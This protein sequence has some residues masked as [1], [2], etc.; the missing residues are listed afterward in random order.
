MLNN[1]STK[2]NIL[3]VF[4]AIATT[5]FLLVASTFIQKSYSIEIGDVSPSNF[6]ATRQVEDRVTTNRLRDEARDKAITV[7]RQDPTVEVSIE[8]RLNK[9]FEELIN[10]RTINEINLEGD[11]IYDIN[12]D[13]ISSNVLQILTIEEANYIVNMEVSNF[14]QFKSSIYNMFKSLLENGIREDEI[15]SLQLNIYS[16][17]PTLE[18]H[19]D[20]ARVAYA[21][22]S[23][24]IQPNILV[25]ED[26]TERRR[27]ELAE[28]VEP[29]IYLQNQN[30]VNE[31]EIITEEIYYVLQDLGFIDTGYTANFIPIIGYSILIIIIFGIALAYIYL[32]NKDLYQNKNYS[33][34]LFILYMIL[35][36]STRLFINLP[37]IVVPIIIFTMLVGILLDYNLALILNAL[38]TITTLFIFDG[39]LEYM[40][41]FLMS[42]SIAALITKYA[43]K[44][45]TVIICSLVLSV[46]SSIIAISI[47]LLIHKSIHADMIFI[48]IYAF[49]MGLFSII[50][51]VGTL[52]FW[53]TV[54]G[55]IT[56]SKLLDLTNPDNELLRRVSI[57]A[58]GTYHH[59]IIVANLSEGAAYDIKADAV[60]ARVGA[61]F[62]DIGKLKYPQY[63]IENQVGENLHDELEAFESLK[64]I[65]SHIDYGLQLADEKKLPLIIRDIIEQH[66]GNT[67]VK[68]FYHKFKEQ[69]PD[70]DI[71]EDDFRYNGP[72]PKS[73]E[74]AIVMMADTVEAAVRSMVSKRK[75]T[76]DIENFIDIL[77]KDKLDDGQFIDSNLTIKDLDTMKKSFMRVFNGMYHERISYPKNV[78]TEPQNTSKEI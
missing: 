70:T 47:A 66:H 64:I 59:S 56:P 22:L 12:I 43:L 74:A 52:P 31:G 32:Y 63:F 11:L 51:C 7:Y 76:D 4:I 57:E 35:V 28:E 69:N 9:F 68:Y 25:D 18:L 62:H 23:A 26:A 24:Y 1:K 14:N 21:L 27:E 2:L 13:N 40:L 45:N 42:G 78:N 16:D 8:N 39:N 3:L 17:F 44:R 77:I 72:T 36:V 53:E 5:I 19:E 71:S 6:K 61:Y 46:L 60:V 29:I 38:A 49:F 30:I 10:Y 73:K 75:S 58:P 34:L 67:K 41:Y 33:L 15:N 48:V 50:I 20:I 65:K 37:H 55:V 54:F